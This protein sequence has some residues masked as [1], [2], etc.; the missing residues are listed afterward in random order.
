MKTEWI[1][2]EESKFREKVCVSVPTEIICHVFFPQLRAGNIITHAVSWCN[3]MSLFERDLG[4]NKPLQCNKLL[5]PCSEPFPSH[6]HSEALGRPAEKGMM[7]L[8]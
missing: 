2:R 8:N 5:K 4:K 3:L 1:F 6:V 7:H